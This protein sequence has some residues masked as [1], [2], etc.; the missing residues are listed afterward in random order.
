MPVFTARSVLTNA[1]RAT[2]RDNVEDMSIVSAGTAARSY[3]ATN[4]R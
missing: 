2:R 1:A 4:R 3:P